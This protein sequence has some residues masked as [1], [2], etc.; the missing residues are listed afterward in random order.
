MDM[1]KHLLGLYSALYSPEPSWDFLRDT[2]RNSKIL[3]EVMKQFALSQN[4]K[5]EDL[6][7][8]EKKE[9]YQ[10][11]I[12][13]L[14]DPKYHQ[15]EIEN[16]LKMSGLKDSDQISDE[17]N[18]LSSHILGQINSEIPKQIQENLRAN[19]ETFGWVLTGINVAL[20]G[21][22]TLASMGTATPLAAAALMATPVVVNGTITY[23][24]L[25]QCFIG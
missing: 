7:E 6:T 9:F 25:E 15:S 16:T 8:D 21:G 2:Q 23:I 22:V 20:I 10:T 5:L 3:N 13:Q 17:L 4:K 19:H 1:K 14:L 24:H 12:K 18:A 11:Q